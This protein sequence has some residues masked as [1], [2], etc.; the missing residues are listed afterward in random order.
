MNSPKVVIITLCIILITGSQVAQG[1]EE[2]FTSIVGLY[3]NEHKVSDS[4][5]LLDFGDTV[6]LP[7]NALGK[8]LDFNV[9]LN[10]HT[11]TAL[12]TTPWDQSTATIDLSAIS[13]S[14]IADFGD[15]F[16]PLEQAAT[17]FNVTINWYP[18][19]Q[20]LAILADRQLSYFRPEGDAEPETIKN[21]EP[22]LV[23][24]VPVNSTPFISFGSIQY[25]L[26]QG[27]SSDTTKWP[28]KDQLSLDVHLQAG[29]SP[30]DIFGHFE[31]LL[32][33]DR[34]WYLDRAT[35]TYRSEEM[36]IVLGD[37]QFSLEKILP[38][39]PIRGI[40]YTS[41]TDWTSRILRASTDIE[42]YAPE[43]SQIEL[44]V[45]G[46]YFGHVTAEDGHYTFKAIPLQIIQV[47]TVVIT[48]TES[49]GTKY[50]ETRTIA[51]TPRLLPAGKTETI[52]GYGAIRDEKNN[53][54]A[55]TIAGT[56]IRTGL[57]NVTTLGAEI[58]R[59]T[60]PADSATPNVLTGDINLAFRVSDSMVLDCDW[61]VS[62]PETSDAQLS[63]G[64]EMAATIQRKLYTI[65]S[66]I[67]YRQPALTLF[68]T[69]PADQ[70]GYQVIAEYKLSKQFG[71]EAHYHKSESVS[72]RTDPSQVVGTVFR[73]LPSTN[74][75]VV[76]KL[77]REIQKS[78]EIEL[79][80]RWMSP[81]AEVN[82]N[83]RWRHN[84]DDWRD[85]Q[86]IQ[87]REAIIR[88][89]NTRTYA[90]LGRY[91]K[92]DWQSGA[93]IYHKSNSEA[94]LSSY[95]GIYRLVG[96]AQAEKVHTLNYSN[97]EVR[98]TFIS[99]DASRPIKQIVLGISAG[100]KNTYEDTLIDS[101][102]LE[103]I[104]LHTGTKN[105][106]VYSE[107][108]LS[109]SQPMQTSRYNEV[110]T[111]DLFTSCL[112]KNGLTFAVGAGVKS[113]PEEK[114][115]YQVNLTL[116]QAIGFSNGGIKGFKST[117]GRPLGYV[118]GV[119]Y[120]D[121]NGNGI[122]DSNEETIPDIPVTLEGRRTFTDENGYY[123]FNHVSPGV[124]RLGFDFNELPAD[125]TPQ[126]D[127]KLIKLL[128]NTNYT[129][130]MA[131]HLNGTIEGTVFYDYNCNGKFDENEQHLDWIK[132]VLDGG[133]S[134]SFTDRRGNFAFQNVNLGH[135]VISVD[136]ESIPEWITAPQPVTIE[137][138]RDN[139]DVWGLLIP[140]QPKPA[141]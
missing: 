91:D 44:T 83:T 67:F 90:S 5:E 18:A 78:D 53:N 51:A 107:L 108:S 82:V 14:P 49:D 81:K 140:L 32:T 45:N 6:L 41:P 29:G 134:S 37:T 39:T 97:R 137:I 66:V 129:H 4:F 117:S 94:Q 12:L 36:A 19:T 73:Y 106:K 113:M 85:S 31:Q 75:S 87:S 74:H 114:P 101:V 11:K 70:K 111:A 7:L 76:L 98:K 131:V 24:Q 123:C 130:N 34:E 88:A 38:H 93:V 109:H 9:R 20:N 3:I 25:S 21:A 96:T 27:F 100:L 33:N 64:V 141:T 77:E 48:V 61:L 104:Y 50:S 26:E 119:V 13:P 16:I 135:H 63:Q 10:P 30:I 125:Y 22:Q 58:A 103:S 8:L 116:S 133:S 2:L 95:P 120:V 84:T 68:S 57:N 23:T 46:Y 52:A 1:A 17:L 62:R 54:W 15:F 122:H 138:T 56:G 105:G 47:N 118:E 136:P 60:T 86:S 59:K 80:Y 35:A 28:P 89:L 69:E 112:L 127:A 124:Y 40:R 43:G 126:T 102:R 65:Q 128:P 72:Q 55:G 121:L 115:E 79:D 71:I 92:I 139:L 42:G 110:W 99:F 132:V